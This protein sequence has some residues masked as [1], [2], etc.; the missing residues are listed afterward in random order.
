MSLSYFNI[1]LVQEF[2]IS[3]VKLFF[4]SIAGLLYNVQDKLLYFPN[5]P[6]TSRFYVESPSSIGI[7]FEN[8]FIR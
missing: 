3:N 7:P 8:V 4:V 2:L 6:P 1:L 5:Q